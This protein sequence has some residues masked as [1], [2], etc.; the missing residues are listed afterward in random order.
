MTLQHPILHQMT[1][2]AGHDPDNNFFS[3]E[4]QDDPPQS[5]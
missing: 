1:H 4:L 5:V 2:H 3:S